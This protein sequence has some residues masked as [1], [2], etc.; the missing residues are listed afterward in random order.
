MN[1]G[2]LTFGAAAAD[3][4]LHLRKDHLVE[5]DDDDVSLLLLLLPAAVACACETR[6]DITPPPV[7]EGIVEPEASA[8]TCK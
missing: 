4:L 7:N 6:L 1:H 8:P 2:V 5:V 3:L